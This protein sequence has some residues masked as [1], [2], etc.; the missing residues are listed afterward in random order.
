[1][2]WENLPAYFA[3]ADCGNKA[4]VYEG[5]SFRE[6]FRHWGPGT[7]LACSMESQKVAN[8]RAV[9]YAIRASRPKKFR[10]F[11]GRTA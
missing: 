4:L 1:M 2:D 11:C 3:V 7:F 5:R 6:A 10:V 8:R 9:V